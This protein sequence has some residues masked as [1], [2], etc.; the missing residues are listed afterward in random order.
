[1]CSI[2]TASGWLLPEIVTAFVCK[3]IS[4]SKRPFKLFLSVL[5]ILIVDVSYILI[6]I[7]VGRGITI[8]HLCP[9]PQESMGKHTG[10]LLTFYILSPVSPP[11]KSTK[12]LWGTGIDKKDRDL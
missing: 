10:S 7:L 3:K 4:Q 9:H 6:A 1:M 11:C 8:M 5:Y 12:L 2:H